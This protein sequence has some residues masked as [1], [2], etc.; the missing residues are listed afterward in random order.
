MKGRTMDINIQ[1]YQAFIKTVEYGS[2]TKAAEVLNYS[3][4]GISRIIKDLEKEWNITLLE[5]DRG[6]V[7]ITS[8]GLRILPLIRSTYEEY[9]KLRM[10][11]DSINGLDSGL[12]RIGSFS[13]AATH[14]IPNMIHHFQKRYPNIDFE[15][16][17][18]S[19]TKV[20]NMIMDGT[21]DC[22]FVVLPTHSEPET[23]VLEHDPL[24]ILLPKDHPL[25]KYDK[26]PL[27]CLED[28]PFILS[29]VDADSE[30]ADFMAAHHVNLNVRFTTWDDYAIMSM[31]EKDLG[32][33]MLSG[34]ILRKI[35]YDIVIKEL[36]VP[37]ARTIAFI[38]RSRKYASL[39]VRRFIDYLDL[40][41][42]A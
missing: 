39:A 38:L 42:E 37:A 22:G 2:F 28:Y 5:R 11:I 23:I 16:Y 31:V 27:S 36:E 17:Q 35:P 29:K 8:E 32:I 9:N 33:S 15:L 12:V 10:E 21:L 34:M 6:G 4:S 30:V 19:Y 1:K 18:G 24:Y 3:Q 20:E 25:T 7:H 26:I 13:S 41:E 40:R 14:W